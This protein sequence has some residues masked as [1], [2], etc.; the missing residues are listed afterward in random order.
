[1]AATTTIF[2]SVPCRKKASSI[3]PSEDADFLT[4]IATMI[5]PQTTDTMII[6]DIIAVNSRAKIHS[7]FVHG[8]NLS[9]RVRYL[10]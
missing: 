9:L 7:T 3:R 10:G 1:M 5:V 4:I 2:R 6:A 8:G